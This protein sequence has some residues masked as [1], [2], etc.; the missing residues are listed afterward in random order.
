M[1]LGYATATIKW[2]QEG[3][4]Q[5]Q[6]ETHEDSER[7]FSTA[8]SKLSFAMS[9]HGSNSQRNSSVNSWTQKRCPGYEGE[10]QE[11]RKGPAINHHLDQLC[12]MGLRL[13]HLFIESLL[14]ICIRSCPIFH[15]AEQ[16]LI[17]TIILTDKCRT[18]TCRSRIIF[19]HI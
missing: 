17:Q 3:L 12:S 13:H 8:A 16:H 10:N 9:V 15:I 18:L 1:Y 6:T 19:V 5:L 7:F 2:S 14:Y 4:L 11:N